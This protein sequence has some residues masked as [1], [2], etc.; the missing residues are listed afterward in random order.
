MWTGAL[1]R[2]DIIP[3]FTA[4]SQGF[5][6]ICWV[7]VRKVALIMEAGDFCV[8]IVSTDSKDSCCLYI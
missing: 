8:G 1:T 6:L 2:F 3:M 7:S 5:L 4:N